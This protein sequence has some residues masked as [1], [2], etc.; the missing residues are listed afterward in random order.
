MS[1]SIDARL[2]AALSQFTSDTDD[3]P[4]VVDA[5][6]ARELLNH[7]KAINRENA[8][9]WGLIPSKKGTDQLAKLYASHSSEFE[10]LAKV[11]ADEFVSHGRS[12]DHQLASAYT[13]AVRA[14]DNT[15]DVVDRTEALQLIGRAQAMNKEGNWFFG[16][17]KGTRG[18]EELKTMAGRLGEA[19]DPKAKAMVDTFVETGRVTGVVIEWQAAKPLWHCHWFPMRETKEGG[20]DPRNNLFATDGALDKYD[21]V[22]GTQSREYE[23]ANNF[24]AHDSESSDASWAG[25]CNNASEIACMLEEPKRSVTYEGVTF[26]PRDIAGLL[27]KVSRSLANRVDFEGRRYN[28]DGDDVGEPAPHDFLEKVIKAWGGGEAPIPFVLDIDREEQVWNYPYDQG[29]VVESSEAPSDFDTD[30]LP[31]GGIIAFYKAELKGTTFDAQARTYEFWV[32]Y[33]D[34][35]E[36]MKSDWIQGAD[37]KINPDFAWRPHPRGDLSKKENWVT[38][39]WKQN[40]PHIRAEDVFEIYS[41]S[42]A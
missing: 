9:F 3:T 29:K 21:Q 7:A 34:D 18:T 13:S 24:R 14:T 25:H 38:S 15:H 30:L 16:L 8:W 35:G 37:P 4:G 1:S 39:A 36:V 26:T 20:G 2:S 33:D 17:F 11:Y 12:V 32:Q 23:L 22:F 41:R 28:G 10:P 5:S 27:V 42:I 6:E 31:E 19:F 40:N